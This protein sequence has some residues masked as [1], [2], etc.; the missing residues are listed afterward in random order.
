[1]K[2]LTCCSCCQYYYCGE[3]YLKPRPVVVDRQDCCK[4]GKR[5]EVEK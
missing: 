1:M 3:C 4:H 5:K 2:S